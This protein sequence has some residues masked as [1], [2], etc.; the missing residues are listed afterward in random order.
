MDGS[1]YFQ[2]NQYTGDFVQGQRHGQGTFS[3][4][5]GAFYEGEWKNDKKDGK[6]SQKYIIVSGT[7]FNIIQ[8]KNLKIIFVLLVLFITI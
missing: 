3:Y 8:Q 4:A 7:K 2:C 1:Q 6:V 5:G